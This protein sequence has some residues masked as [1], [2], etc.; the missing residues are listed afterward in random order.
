MANDR[1]K[2][3]R[4]V[5][6][7]HDRRHCFYYFDKPGHDRVRLPGVPGSTEFMDAYQE[8][9]AAVVPIAATGRGRSKL[10]SV[11]MAVALYFGSIAFGNLNPTTQRVRHRILERFREEYGELSFKTLTRGHVETMLA[12]KAAT[13]H[14]A[15]HFRNALRAVAAVAIT[16]GLR[17]DD[18][19]AGVTNVKVR[20]S[21]GFRT[22][23]ESEI[24]QFEARHPINSRARLAFGLLLF[25]AQRRGDIIRMGRQHVRGGF[26]SVRQQKTGAI[27]E[28][29]V[30]PELQAILDAHPAEHLTFLTTRAG[31]PF[32]AAGFTGWFRDRCKDAGLPSGLSAHGLRKAACRRLAEAGCSVVHQIAAISGHASLKEVQRYT[33]AADQ[34]RMAVDAMAVMVSGTKGVENCDR[35]GKPAAPNRKTL[36]QPVEKKGT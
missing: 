22:W 19:T 32:T 23:D 17:D 14:A 10:G 3:V 35:A 31:E 4:K 21:E 28:I 24:A 30:L 36:A 7:R 18:P 29:P 25:T 26:I 33:R 16:A 9:I 13:P 8:A 12:A 6:S 34:K 11:A 2:Y 27:L 15:R 1:L 5:R 20:A